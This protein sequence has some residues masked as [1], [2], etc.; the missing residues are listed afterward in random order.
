MK[1]ILGMGLT[2]LS[3][4]RFFALNGITYRIG[5]SRKSPPLLSEF[6]AQESTEACQLGPWQEGLLEGVDEII[7]SPGIAMSEKIIVWAKEK[8]IPLIGDIELFSRYANAPIIGI[9][10]SNGKSTVTQ[11]VGEM[12]LAAGKKTAICGNIGVPVMD[13]LSDNVDLYVVELS[14]YQL[15]YTNSLNLLAGLVLNITPDHLDRYPSFEAY[16]ASKISLYSYCQNKVVNLDENATSD[17]VWDCCFSL[18]ESIHKCEFR[19]EVDQSTTTFFNKNEALFD[20]ESLKIVGEHNM[21]NVLAALTL[22]HLAGLSNKAMMQAVMDFK[23]LPH[24]LEWVVNMDGVDFFNDSKSTNAISTITAINALSDSYP[25]LVLIAGGI[26]KKEDYSAMFE[27]IGEK[28]EAVVFIGEA[29]ESFALNTTNCVVEIAQSMEQA[30]SIAK[31]YAAGGAVLLSPACA[32]FDMYEDF[33]TRGDDFKR[34]LS[35]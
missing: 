9:S 21:S 22:G 27:L 17:I 35:E 18:R 23:G 10:G 2:G 8:D 24:R 6:I 26:A 31:C 5:D 14:S 1:L 3:V 33:N 7:A 12:G 11:L 30:L 19:V 15:D 16:V 13:A 34:L 25:S 29:A 28:A 4:A 20:S 32:S